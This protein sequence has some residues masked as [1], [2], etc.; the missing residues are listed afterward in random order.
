VAGWWDNMNNMN[1]MNGRGI[2]VIL[3]IIAFY[4]ILTAPEQSAN[5]AQNTGTFLGEAVDRF[6]VFLDSLT[7]RTADSHPFS[8]PTPPP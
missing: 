3:L 5:T 2:L 7:E 6:G 1:R 4:L 8:P